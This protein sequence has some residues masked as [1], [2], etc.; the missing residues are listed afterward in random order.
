VAEA[1][2][3][4]Q[5]RLTNELAQGDSAS[6]L[7][8]MENLFTLQTEISEQMN[9]L[10]SRQQRRGMVRRDERSKGYDRFQR[11]NERFTTNV[12]E[13]NRFEQQQT[14]VANLQQTKDFK[15]KA[16]TGWADK[17]GITG[18]E[19]HL[20]PATTA[21]TVAGVNA[22]PFD[23]PLTGHPFYFE[24]LR[25]NAVLG[26]RSRS[27]LWT[28]LGIR[29][30]AAAAF[31]LLAAMSSR[32]SWG[33]RLF[34]LVMRRRVAKVVVGVT[35]VGLFLLGSPLGLALIAVTV[36]AYLLNRRRRQAVKTG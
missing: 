18:R 30:A 21:P 6:Q 4:E 5:T 7:A 8:A 36:F 29:F 34:R 9:E 28:R 32:M 31:F 10:T 33:G 22:L 3:D 26:F 14:Q 13:Q 16:P 15:Q 1:Y 17:G 23:L 12:A 2:L 19:E 27:A 11:L 20:A 24:K 25:G 35:G